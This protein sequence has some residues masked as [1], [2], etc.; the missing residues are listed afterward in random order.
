MNASIRPPPIA[1]ASA[2]AAPPEQ[3]PRERIARARSLARRTGAYWKMSALLFVLGCIIAVGVAFTVKRIYRSECV[4]LVKPAMKTDDRDESPSEKAMK[5]APKLK[6]TLLTRSRLEPIIKEYRLYPT[7]VESKGM[8]DAIEEMRLHI[9]LRGRDSETFVISFEAEDPEETRAVTQRLADTTMADFKKTNLSAS[10]QQANF[11]ATEEQRSEQDIE[12]ANKALA[13]FLAAHPEFAADTLN[14]P[15]TPQRNGVP[16][17]V[18]AG[19]IT[20]IPAQPNAPMDP[21]LAAL[22]R[23]KSR[24]EAEIKAGAAGSGG[25]AIQAP[26][27]ETVASLTKAR[28]DAAR[29]AAGAQAD[30]ADKRTHY[31]EQ[32]PDVV[33]ARAMADQAAHTLHV[34]EAQLESAKAGGAPTPVDTSGASPELQK[35][36]TEVGQEIG[37]RHADVLRRGA[38]PVNATDPKPAETTNP[39][40][41]LETDWARLLRATSDA[42]AAHDE[43]QRGAERAKLHASAAEAT[44]GDQMEVID[45]AYKPTRPARGGRTNAA[46]IGAAI[47]LI[48]SVGYAFLRVLLN[49][50]IIDAADIE[51]LQLIPVLGIMPRLPAS[52][53]NPNRDVSPG[54]SPRVA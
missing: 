29:R 43:I 46:L 31:T 24:I 14:S 47:A 40:V 39:L 33:A 44:S 51:A 9:G 28:D 37:L 27:N 5:L 48:V 42:K 7:T 13:T 19:Q 17:G 50:T 20:N 2:Q 1:N 53:E 38:G 34:T 12:N 10:R 26:P 6:D 11:L 22:Y 45:P 3:S 18:S 52:N 32:H 49:D 35:K 41:A 21:Q 23:Q 4:V 8:I 54:G 36:L 15:F 25:A 16:G 30:L